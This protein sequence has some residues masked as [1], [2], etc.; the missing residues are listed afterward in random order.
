MSNKINDIRTDEL[1]SLREEVTGNLQ[2]IV[3]HFH[4]IGLSLSMAERNIVSAQLAMKAI[5]ELLINSP[6][7]EEMDSKD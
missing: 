3:T 7:A 1:V 4:G 6:S 2:D 5:F